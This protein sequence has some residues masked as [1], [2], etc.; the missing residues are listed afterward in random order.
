MSGI[1]VVKGGKTT[2]RF[3]KWVLAVN[4][5]INGRVSMSWIPCRGTFPLGLFHGSSDLDTHLITD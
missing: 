1:L 2:H 3:N 4:N 5:A